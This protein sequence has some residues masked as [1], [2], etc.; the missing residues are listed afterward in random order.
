LFENLKQIEK[1]AIIGIMAL[2]RE[3]QSEDKVD[4]SVGVY[5]DDT[6][7]TP[8]MSAI[9]KAE[10]ELLEQEKTKSYVGIAGLPKFN[11]AISELVFG[12]FYHKESNRIA[13]IQTPGGSGGLCVA[14]HLINRG[15][16][17]ATVWAS[18]PTW[19]NHIPLLSTSG[20]T[21]KSYDYYDRENNEIN[22]SR[23]MSSLD[24]SAP[25][26]VLLLHGCCHNPC[27][28]DLNMDQWQSVLELINKKGL[29]P[30]VD[31][32]YLGLGDGV[33]EDASGL[34]LLA[35]NCKEMI[36]V[37]S[38]SKN[39]GLYKER[40]GAVSAISANAGESERT[41]SNLANIARSIYSMPPDHGAALAAKVL[42]DTQ[43]R[44]NWLEELAQL[45]NRIK[46]V[47][48]ELSDGL[49]TRQNKIDFSFIKKE[50]GMF[51]FLGIS[52]DHVIELRERFHIYMVESSRINIAGINQKNI[53]YIIES[54]CHV[55]D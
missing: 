14:G 26:D 55:I 47:R 33:D 8:I 54:I 13:T 17:G 6:G 36:V 52:R 25:G 48:T 27:G 39:L 31:L 21:I 1:D 44:E 7:V 46:Q 30:L 38:C 5:Q 12:S 9:K 42:T 45:R 51:S 24:S 4:L 10:S 16:Q 3:D 34:R 2:F 40:V 49:N 37:T 53:S 18:T 32:A 22:F 43:L 19:P 50:K 28:A 29:L 20:L 41:L 35:N 15:K 23:M 11:D